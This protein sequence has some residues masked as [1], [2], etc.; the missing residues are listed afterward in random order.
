MSEIKNG[1]R[2]RSFWTGADGKR[3]PIDRMDREHAANAA[4]W[5][6]ANAVP[7]LMTE[8]V[9]KRP[10]QISAL[11]LAKVLADPTGTISRTPLHKALMAR[12][13]KP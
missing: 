12:A 7:L 4:A 9:E 1:L 10:E 8:M 5:L 2:Q 11:D 13:A 3:R 6:R